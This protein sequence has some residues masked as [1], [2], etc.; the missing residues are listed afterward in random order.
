M[1]HI[2]Y[3]N[4]YE[5]QTFPLASHS[6]N[7]NGS[8]TVIDNSLVIPDITESVINT[9]FLTIDDA[10]GVVSHSPIPNI[11]D[12]SLNT[13][14]SPTFSGLTVTGVPK[15]DAETKLLVLDSVT[16]SLEYRDV[17]SLPAK[18]PFDQNLNTTNNPTF[19]KLLLADTLEGDLNTKVL[20]INTGSDVVEFK[21]ISS[22]PSVNPF[23]QGLDTTDS[24]T[25]AGVTLTGVLQDDTNTKMLSIDSITNVVEWVEKDTINPGSL[26]S[27]GGTSLVND[28]TGPSLAT[29]GLV[30]GTNVSFVDTGTTI[31]IIAAGTGTTPVSLGS[32]GGT[33]TLV[34]DGTGPDMFVKGLTAG[35]NITLTPSGTDVT[36]TSAGGNPFDQTLNTTDIVE[37]DAAVMNNIEV[38]DRPMVGLAQCRVRVAE[39]PGSGFFPAGASY[40]R[41]D[42]VEGVPMMQHIGIDRHDSRLYFDSGLMNSGLEISNSVNSNYKVTKDIDSLIISGDTLTPI[43]DACTFTDL[44]SINN[45]EVIVNTQLTSQNIVI[46]AAPT[47][48]TAQNFDVLVRNS[49][50]PFESRSMSESAHGSLWTNFN[51]TNNISYAGGVYSDINMLPSFLNNSYL[52]TMPSDG[53]LQYTGANTARFEMTYGVTYFNLQAGDILLNTIVQLNGLDVAPSVNAV[54]VRSPVNTYTEISKTFF[55]ELSTNDQLNVGSQNFTNFLDMRVALLSMSLKKLQDTIVVNNAAAVYEYNGFTGNVTPTTLPLNV[56]TKLSY[57]S[58]S[59]DHL[60]T[61]N[62]FTLQNIAGTIRVLYTGRAGIFAFGGSLNG[63]RTGGGSDLVDLQYRINGFVGDYVFSETFETGVKKTLLYNEGLTPL[64]PGDEIDV[65]ARCATSTVD[66]MAEQMTFNFILIA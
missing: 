55:I 53:V 29:K 19:Q 47:I 18:N 66:L 43:G 45:S 58:T 28:G 10:A 12:Q 33:E 40:Q 41:N 25:F 11:F 59:W 9:K 64:S 63:Y 57:P 42:H 26:V 14:D 3:N 50:N 31:E 54:T 60:V 4:T 62:D 2:I 35:A 17:Q 44:M 34:N 16:N 56:F 21:N 65:Y 20:T 27:A 5:H 48:N 30:A 39:T 32:A 13:T 7:S 36:I 38:G 51:S 23:D 1:S 15:D 6:V 22:F 49:N 24:P 46:P 37:F 52:F 61:T 8:T